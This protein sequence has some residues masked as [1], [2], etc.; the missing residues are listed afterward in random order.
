MMHLLDSQKRRI[1]VAEQGAGG[2][3]HIQGHAFLS[4]RSLDCGEVKSGH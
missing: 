3:V 1:G 2:M 4:V